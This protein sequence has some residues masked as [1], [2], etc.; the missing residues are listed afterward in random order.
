MKGFKAEVGDRVRVKS[1][2]SQNFE[3]GQIIIVTQVNDIDDGYQCRAERPDSTSHT[4][5]D[6]EIEPINSKQ[7]DNMSDGNIGNELKNLNLSEEDRLLTEAGIIDECQNVTD[8]GQTILWRYILKSNMAAL[9]KDLKQLE[10]NRKTK[11]D[12]KK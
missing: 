12:A 11:V 3:P 10:E 4:M 7:G 2:S 8:E 1:D 6:Y 5:C 9:I